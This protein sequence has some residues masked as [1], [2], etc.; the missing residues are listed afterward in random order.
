M[1]PPSA[2]AARPLTHR[3]ALVTGA[4]SGIG[5]ATALRLAEGGAALQLVARRA[6]RLEQTVAAARRHGVSCEGHV[7]DV[8]DARATTELVQQLTERQCPIDILINNAG[9]ARGW[10]DVVDADERDWQEMLDTNVLALMRMTRLVLPLLRARP[11]ADLVQVGSVAGVQPY[12]RGAAYCASKAA[13]EAFAQAL[14]QE[15][16]G[17]AVRQLVIEPGMVATE[18]SEVRFH[19]DA[20]RARAVYEGLEPLSAEDVADAICW[21]L[22]RPPHVCVQSMLLMPTAQATATQVARRPR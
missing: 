21:S 12:P 6:D 10:D 15:L 3:I 4:S 17:S 5:R 2:P 1:S 18:F 19:G 9:L 11:Y 8:R 7:L 14:R 16:L 20:P 22:T 13:V